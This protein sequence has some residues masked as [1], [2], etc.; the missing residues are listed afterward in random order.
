MSMKV[1]RSTVE[2]VRERFE[3]HKRKAQEKTEVREYGVVEQS[4]YSTVVM[5]I[6]SCV[7]RY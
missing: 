7:C 5:F 1:E 6:A 4:G 3:L 2:Q